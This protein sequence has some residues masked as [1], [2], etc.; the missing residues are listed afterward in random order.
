MSLSDKSDSINER[1]QEINEL[2]QL[3]ILGVWQYAHEF[4]RQLAS[5]GCCCWLCSWQK[6]WSTYVEHCNGVVIIYIHFICSP[7][8]CHL[9]NNST[10]L[11]SWSRPH[12]LSTPITSGME[13]VHADWKKYNKLQDFLTIV[14]FLYHGFCTI[15]TITAAATICSTCTAKVTRWNPFQIWQQYIRVGL[16]CSCANIWYFRAISVSFCIFLRLADSELTDRK[17]Q[18][19]RIDFQLQFAKNSIRVYDIASLCVVSLWSYIVHYDAERMSAVNWP[20]HTSGTNR[21]SLRFLA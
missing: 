13:L 4:I 16:R 11:T 18:S 5:C 20:L 9:R 7:C 15:T 19:H 6:L 12:S 17:F 14:I 10:T 3:H 2:I 1:T 8:S 21:L